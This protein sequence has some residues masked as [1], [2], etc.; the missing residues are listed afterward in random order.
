[1]QSKDL[2][3]RYSFWTIKNIFLADYEL[4]LV[5]VM[6][7]KGSRYSAKR[8]NLVRSDGSIELA[9]VTLDA[10]REYLLSENY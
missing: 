2:K 10:L 5:P 4:S 8:Y 1:M 9:N 3:K 7:Y 6:A